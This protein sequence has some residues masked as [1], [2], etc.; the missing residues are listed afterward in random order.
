MK[1]LSLIF[2]ATLTIVSVGI[3][4]GAEP[5]TTKPNYELAERFSPT[6]VRRV[7]PQTEVRPNWFKN[8]SKFWYSWKTIVLPCTFVGVF[9]S[10]D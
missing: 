4:K 2:A 3:A 5:E 10:I 1:K 8:S 7:V 6:K 9:T